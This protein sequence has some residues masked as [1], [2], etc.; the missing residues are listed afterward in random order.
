[1]ERI[2]SALLKHGLFEKAGDFFEKM[3]F[4]DRALGAYR[5]GHCYR[6]AVELARREF[7]D[8][9]VGLEEEWGEHCLSLRQSDQ[10]VKHLIEA[11]KVGASLRWAGTRACGRALMMNPC[12]IDVCAWATRST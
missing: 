8:E 10:A 11:G 3:N 12:A 2:A 7:P 5:K 1:M 6:R 9:V 4:A